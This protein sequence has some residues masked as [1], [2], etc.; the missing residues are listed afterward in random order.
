M[1][2]QH[3]IH[4]RHHHNH[5]HHHQ[6]QQN[7]RYVPFSNPTRYPENPNFQNPRPPNH[8]HSNLCH[9][10]VPPPPP[11][12][13]PPPPP[14]PP[15][16]SSYHHPLPPPPPP[17][18]NPSQSSKFAF[19]NNPNHNLPFEEHSRKL[20]HHR[21][22]V[23][24]AN[25][26][27]SSHRIPVDDDRPPPPHRHHQH[28]YHCY[29][30]IRSDFWDQSRVVAENRPERPYT[31]LRGFEPDPHKLQFDHNKP[32][33]PYRIT[34]KFRHDLEGISRTRGEYDDG[35]EPKYRED[36]L[37]G[38]D[39]ENYYR[40]G[41]QFSSGGSDTSFR[42]LGFVSD[43][44]G[45]SRDLELNS[46]SNDGR[47]G[48][49]Y[50][51]E[52]FRSG[53]GDGV[54]EN[55]R[56][57]H[58][59]KHNSWFERGSVENSVGDGA[60][61]VYGKREYYGSE[62]GRYSN[63]GSRDGSHEYNRTPR[64]QL[65][66]KSALLRIQVAKPYRRSV[67]SGQLHYSGYHD[68]SGSSSFRR[69]DHQHVYMSREMDDEEEEE[70][71]E[72]SPVELDVSFKSNALVAKAIMAPSSSSDVIDADLNL[73][74]RKLTKDSVFDGDI[75]NSELTELSED[76]V[77][78][79]NSTSTSDKELMKSEVKVTSGVRSNCL[80][81]KHSKD[82]VNL[83]GSTNVANTST[84]DT[85]LM[86]SE[87]KITSG[88]KNNRLN[89][90]PTK[91]SEDAVNLHRSTHVANGTST[92]NN[93]LIKLE[94]KRSSGIKGTVLDKNVTRTDSGKPS[95]SKV[96][97]KKK[98]VRKIVKSSMHP[99][100]SMLRSQP[101]NKSNQPLTA[102]SCVHSP[103]AALGTD[104]GVRSSSSP[105][106]VV[107]KKVEE[108]SPMTMKVEESEIDVN[109]H[110][111]C[112]NK[113]EKN[114]K[115]STSALCSPSLEKGK[116]DEV[117]ENADNSGLGLHA[118]SK[119]NKSLTKL[120]GVTSPDDIG[121]MVDVKQSCKAKETSVHENGLEKES[122][123]T[124]LHGGGNSNSSL[125][126]SGE[127]KMHEDLINVCYTDNSTD[128]TLH[129]V[130]GEKLTKEENSTCDI[131]TIDV[132][133]KQPCGLQVSTSCGNGISEE[134]S[135]VTFSAGSTAIIGLSSSG[136]G[137]MDADADA[138]QHGRGSIYVSN[139]GCS[140][141]EKN[142]IISDSQP[143]DCTARKPSQDVAIALPENDGTGKSPKCKISV[144]DIGLSSS[145]ESIMDADTDASQHGRGS[146]CVAGSGCSNYEENIIISDSR[147]IDCAA[148]KPSQDSAIVLP[149]NGSTGKS[150]KHK[151]SVGDIGLSSSGESITDADTGAS[152]HGRG[153][154]C[155]SGSGCSN[156]EENIIISDSQPMD[157]AARK[158][159]QEGAIALPEN[160]GTGKSPKHKISVGDIGLSSS[161]ESIMD[162]DTDASQHDRGSICVSGSGCSNCEENIAIS[163]SQPID[164]AVTKPSPD[165]GIALPENG[166]TGKSPKCKISV[167][168]IEGEA[169]I[170]KKKRT[171][172][173]WLDFSR[174]S[175]TDLE[176]ASVS[177]SATAVDKTLSLIFKNPSNEAEVSCV[178][179]LDFG[180]R[181]C[182]DGNS[183]VDGYPEAN[184]VPR[185]DVNN[186]F[187]K[188]P[189]QC[190]KRR[191]VSVSPLESSSLATSQINEQSGNASS[192]FVKAPLTGNVALT[193]QK[194]KIGTTSMDALCVTTNLM[195]CEKE[196]TLLH[197]NKLIRESFDAVDAARS[198]FLDGN[199]K[200]EHQCFGSS[201]L[202][203]SIIPSFQP[204]CPS[205]S[206][207][208]QKKDDASVMPV[209]NH[210]ID[211]IKCE[212]EEK[213]GVCASKE[214]LINHDET[215]QCTVLS[216]FHPPDIDQRL[217]CTST[218]SDDSLVKDNLP[219]DCSGVSASTCNDEPMEIV[220]DTL[221][222][223]SSPQT[224]FNVSDTPGLGG[225]V[226]FSQISNDSCRNDKNV[227]E[228]S[229][230][231]GG[232]D[233]SAQISLS[234]CSKSNVKLDHGSEVSGKM[235]PLPLKDTKSMSSGL[236][237]VTGEYNGQKNQAG[238]T[239]TK[240][241]PGHA[242][243]IYPMVK[244]TASSTQAK[245]RTWHRSANPS[246]SSV[247]ESNP[248]PRTASPN[249]QLPERDGK[250][251][252]SS[253]VRKGNSLVRKPSP[254]APL[255]KG[256]HGFSSSVYRLNY[257][258]IDELK[259]GTISDH[260]VDI[261]NPSHLSRTGGMNAYFDRP[262]TSLLTNSI[263]LPNSTA[264]L[265]GDCT[266]SLQSEPF[267]GCSEITSNPMRSSENNDTHNF[268][269]DS[270][271]TS[272]AL[273]NQN[274][275]PNGFDN[276]TELNDGNLAS[277]N[278]K[279]IVYV[280]HKSN[281]LV[282]T[283]NSSDL[284]IPN[285][286]KIQPSSFDGY[287]KRRTNQLI[288]TSLE[289]QTRP[290]V[291]VPDDNLNSEVQE[292]SKA[293]SIRFG[294]R[295]SYKDV[296]KSS[297]TSK[298]SL[299]WTLCGTQS[300]KNHGGSVGHLKV[301]PHLFPW[302]R[303]AYWRSFIHSRN[304]FSK[305][306][307]L[308][309]IS[310]KLL[311][312]RKRDAVYTRSSNG[313]SLRKSKVLSVGGSS[314]KWSKSI[315]RRAKKVNE[316][317]T[318]AVAE[319]ERKKR[320]Q[321]RENRAASPGSKNRNNSPRERIFRIGSVRYKMDP[322]RQT[323]QRISDDESS[324]S[325]S[326]H[327]DKEAKISYIPRRLVIGNDEYI[328]IGNGNQL[329]RNPKKRTRILASAKVRWSLHTARLR[330]ARKRKYCQ[331][332]TRFG[333]CNKED[334]K[335]PYIH[336]PSKVAVCTKFLNGLCFNTNCKLTHKVIPERMPDCSYF[337]Q[338][339]CT[340]QNCPYRHVNV[341]PKASTC[342]EFLRGYCADGN[343][344]RKKHSYVC[345]IFEATGTCPQ[346]SKCKL[347]HPKNRTKGKKRKRTGEKK[348]VQGR[349]FGSMHINVVGPITAVSEKL[350][351]QAQHDNDIA[352]EGKFADFISIDVSDDEAG[353]SNDRESEQATL[354]D[355][356]ISQFHLDGLDE[357]IKPVRIMD[358]RIR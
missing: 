211:D 245:P 292:A 198:S 83:R 156:H 200:V 59:R 36:I 315:E 189:L 291:V 356:D 323:L 103:S 27:S 253:Y 201:I 219:A 203:E 241:F 19:S 50:N 48:L 229:V 195:P 96:V 40:G 29:P 164:C 152:Q 249:R 26:A 57:G 7:P 31:P 167:G 235:V 174:T 41:G 66:K 124:L 34:E 272:E 153:S 4:H 237:I 63:R 352:S 13:P 184:Y 106:P 84:S 285:A 278:M 314:L 97:K 322:S 183:P 37:W 3:L 288:R 267:S 301:F 166:A 102:D 277:S 145:G 185:S 202:G 38:R 208:L 232:S 336:D 85:E 12:I 221:S 353:E 351:G 168:D 280:K 141:Y 20:Q 302:K 227:E 43:Q 64:K 69:K 9:H 332:F 170:I 318:L 269:E 293:I 181:P 157:C 70:E 340:N 197:G 75:V 299:V 295:R 316:E 250:L 335:C 47:Y 109:S 18:Y 220:T 160:G 101:R 246:A 298:N 222:D 55:P 100:S 162:A 105:C 233:V 344:C 190:R 51:D 339:L 147:P 230:V 307:S 25:R 146:I 207:R 151:I 324:C 123:E 275:Q 206:E 239:L 111:K 52:L 349:Y 128:T 98:V 21:D 67:E 238:V 46:G 283:S 132:L 329:I 72:G 345:P 23:V 247:T 262:I 60:P 79:A 309:V 116:I 155:V 224:S 286:D 35:F 118:I 73:R 320:E 171:V 11:A 319:V 304:L 112:V 137:I 196:C 87:G 199:L 289:G 343:E 265:L 258:G 142:I 161:G 341:N 327:P 296:A 45:L 117:P 110:L 15:Q 90:E 77:N 125:L 179:S 310:R 150:P 119:I 1:D 218:E 177:E 143:I 61:V 244:K 133:S 135:K 303:A 68:N 242:S 131:G 16:S 205:G 2:L 8:H 287:Y 321:N 281:Q 81:L 148:M 78:F 10:L 305:T 136:E 173:T 333:K 311:L 348:N 308:S 49:V 28:Q 270:L 191:K 176:P 355:S 328:R 108:G 243:S 88:I 120:L 53:N 300:L 91:L 209:N 330:L 95:S 113:I 236:N 217:P 210:Q 271:R 86:K 193:G 115:S 337:L 347:H 149:E 99:H 312:S 158:P 58:D 331:F 317:A 114:G 92:S 346:G 121:C 76:T 169:P 80:N 297:T 194:K 350:S 326:L 214:E 254:V 65:Q 261:G 273:E 89:S 204:L 251:Q 144:G 5:H 260:R 134:V 248:F 188:T 39:D 107:G 268:A 180:L 186:D 22:F 358:K 255:P 138:S 187:D 94:G 71:R 225:K 274:G 226:S 223:M 240:I 284:S 140:N 234:Q 154:V 357:L 159:S 182:E 313:F 44:V 93:E 228:K 252:S 216:A 257:V 279:R 163:D 290:T 14:P 213:L 342:E 32:V 165:G 30:E 82:T 294:K 130:N 354:S 24:L 256:S 6:Q 139:S 263:K 306:S 104:K 334:G 178:G 17:P 215:A 33:S 192:S 325:V 129:V 42:E 122:S 74:N 264:I 231:D 127:I 266:S 126:N 259:K 175:D 282:A 172:G 56:W 62:L 276:R 338:G 212:R 54:R